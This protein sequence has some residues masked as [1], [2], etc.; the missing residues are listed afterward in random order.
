ME[1]GKAQEMGR[2]MEVGGG[3]S[4]EDGRGGRESG[5]EKRRRRDT[6]VGETYLQCICR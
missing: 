4:E 3:D 1:R 2:V 6:G 5:K